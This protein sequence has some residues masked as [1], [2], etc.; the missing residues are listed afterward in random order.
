MIPRESTSTLSLQ[1]LIN[2]QV[3]GGFDLNT[4]AITVLN[5]GCQQT[6]SVPC[7]RGNRLLAIRPDQP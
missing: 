5:T 1:N 7:T 6:Y 2:G 4:V 3:V